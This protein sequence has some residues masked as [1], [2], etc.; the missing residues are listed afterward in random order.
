MATADKK[1]RVLAPSL[2]SM[3]RLLLEMVEYQTKKSAIRF[4]DDINRMKM[5]PDNFDQAWFT[6]W[7]DQE[8][9]KLNIDYVY[10]MFKR[11]VRAAVTT[12][13][14]AVNRTFPKLSTDHGATLLI[15]VDVTHSE[16][17]DPARAFRDLAQFTDVDVQG[18]W[19]GLDFT[20]TDLILQVCGKFDE[21]MVWFAAAM[22][23]SLDKIR[24]SAMMMS[25]LQSRFQW[26]EKID[27]KVKI[28]Y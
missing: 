19:D 21:F 27:V 26:V 24:E 20:T 9:N 13:G 12:E 2:Q 3:N 15:P 25:K 17:S 4:W 28:L 16:W 6:T 11:F 7:K 14:M 8:V 18:L 10:G 22:R 23:S 1:V 5:S